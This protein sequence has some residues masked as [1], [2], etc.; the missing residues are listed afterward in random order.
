MVFKEKVSLELSTRIHLLHTV[1]NIPVTEICKKYPQISRAS[2]YR[3]ARNSIPILFG[4]NKKNKGGR[5]SKLDIRQERKIIRNT[6]FLQDKEVNFSSKRVRFMANVPNASERT[7]RRVMNKHRYGYRQSRKKGLM[8]KL[9][10]KKRVKFCRR[11]SKEKTEDFWKNGIAF[12]LDSTNF[13]HKMNPQ[14]QAMV[15]KARI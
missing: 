2:V 12:Y 5:P 14:D 10:R 9:D 8:T 1:F 11:I 13:V 15:P 3:H 6:K 4:K 7:V